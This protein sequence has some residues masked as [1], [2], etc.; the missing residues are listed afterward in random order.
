VNKRGLFFCLLFLLVAGTARAE[1]P[2]PDIAIAD[3]RILLGAFTQTQ[4]MQGFDRPLVSTGHFVL[5]SRRG[6]KWNV[7]APFPSVVTITPAGLTQES[8]GTTTSLR[9]DNLP[10]LKE[11]YHL[12]QGVLEGNWRELSGYFTM[13]VAAD[14]RKW[15]VRLVPIKDEPGFPY[16]TITVSGARF[17]ERVEMHNKNGDTETIDFSDIQMDAAP[18]DFATLFDSKGQ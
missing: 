5:A 8:N 2:Y 15:Q 1:T 12:I 6:I 11:M 7:E 17:V 4:A 10:K 9:T 14:G 16:A 18:E 13:V 3:D